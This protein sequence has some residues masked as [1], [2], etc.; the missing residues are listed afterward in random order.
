R[1]E[2]VQLLR[3]FGRYTDDIVPPRQC[4]LYVLR[5]PH[6]AARIRTIDS[7]AA[8]AAPGV[9][10]ILTGADAKADGLGQFA[11]RVQRKRRDGSPN[12]VPPYRVLALDRIHH[13]GEPVAAV[14]AESLAQAKDAA[15]LVAIDWE[16]LPSV[17]DTASA[18]MPG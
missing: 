16:V 9:L 5:S 3:G 4:H 13:V 15:E 8:A 7:A 18:P 12:F 14:I 11:S 17:T 1:T 10:L 2:D 6:A